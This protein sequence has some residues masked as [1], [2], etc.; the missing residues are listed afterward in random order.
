[1][2]EKPSTS[3]LNIYPEARWGGRNN[4]SLL[5]SHHHPISQL[6]RGGYFIKDDVNVILFIGDSYI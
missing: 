6:I 2:E 1:V 5:T 4:A 3:S